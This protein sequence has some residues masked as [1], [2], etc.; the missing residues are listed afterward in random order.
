MP[1]PNA[2][3]LLSGVLLAC[4]VMSGVAHAQ[5]YDVE[6]AAKILPD[7]GIARVTITVA[8]RD[9]QL[10]EV[11]SALEGDHWFDF[12]ADGELETPEAGGFRWLV[13]PRGG[14]LEYSARI[15][16]VRGEEG[17][18]SRCMPDWMLTRA[19]DLFPPMAARFASGARANSTML[20]DV[21]PRWDLVSAFESEGVN[22][23]VEQAGR[24]L[25]QPK[26]WLL[27][28]RIERLS[29]TIA[30][31]VVTIGAPRRHA[32]RLRD[33]MTV[34]RFTLPTLAEAAGRMPARIAIVVGDDPMWRGGL[35][36]PDS[37]FLHADRPFID[38][39]GTSPLIHELVHVITHARN[40]PGYDWL[41]EGLAEYYALQ[42]L[43][44]SGAVSER[45]HAESLER[46]RERGESV[47]RFVGES[48][49]AETAR[50]VWLMHRLDETIR[51][52][53]QGEFDL[54]SVL[55]ALVEDVTVL[56]RERLLEAI[57]RT[58]GVGASARTILDSAP[59]SE[60]RFAVAP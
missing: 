12:A 26:G 51:T 2:Y 24:S 39:D 54:D 43:R 3:E 41:V 46:L 27:A 31:S 13:P 22:F 23:V 59:D 20:L 48:S 21:P 44:R 15:D 58:T 5:T 6:Y 45:T 25:D 7:T 33:T 16:R 30:G 8:Q 37:L 42:V 35:A 4:A 1:R 38:S 34:L 47:R 32:A 14:V 53:T 57:E 17:Y 50:A 18:D 19:E 52:E 28:G 60:P 9:A 11:S 29:E 36:G 40:A 49:G 55:A 10:I 56:D